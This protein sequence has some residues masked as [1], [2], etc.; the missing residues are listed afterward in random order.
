METI[1]YI[2]TYNTPEIDKKEVLRYASVKEN[3]TEINTLLDECILETTD[4]LSYNACYCECPIEITGEEIDLGFT[5]VRSHSLSLCLDGCDRI[6]LFCATVGLEIDRLIARYSSISPSK[7]T[8]L[9]ALGSERV[10]ALCDVFCRDMAETMGRELRPR[11]S[12]GYGD[13]PLEIQRDIFATLDPA[14]RIGV[15]LGDNLFM[16]PSKSVTAIIGIKK[17]Q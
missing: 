17:E 16:T 5:K 2:K 10:E 4:K 8:V 7:A 6:I 15:T 12:A 14:R 11:F 3:T 9:Q 1:V 13:V